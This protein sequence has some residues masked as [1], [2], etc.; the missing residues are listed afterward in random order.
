MI[1]ASGLVG[2][3]LLLALA[4]ARIEAVGTYRRNPFPGG[5]A[6]DLADPAT[7]ENGILQ[8]RPDLVFLAVNV[9]GGVDFVENNPDLAET[10]YVKATEKIAQAA[11]A[12]GA[13]LVYYSTDYL[14][15]GKNG[16]YSEDDAVHPLNVYGRKKLESEEI[17]RKN[18]RDHLIIRTTAVYGW[19]PG[20]KNF[21]MQIWEKLGQK[22]PMRVPNDQWCNPTLASDLAD[23]TLEL[24]QKGGRGIFNIVGRD[25]M[26]RSEMAAALARTM[27]LD[28]RLIQ[29]VPTSETQQ[30]APRPLMGSLKTEKMRKF[31]GTDA[32]PFDRALEI[33]RRDWQSR[34]I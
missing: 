24:Y 18:I 10:I 33:Y 32:L 25:G 5:I 16:P 6:M 8:A 21:A 23:K 22:E 28:P 11:S 14:F 15:D 31:I 9:P 7:L 17:I 34:E 19:H 4:R 29:P 3:A 27:N 2:R 20:T 30:K 26:F 12:N 1:G 13:G